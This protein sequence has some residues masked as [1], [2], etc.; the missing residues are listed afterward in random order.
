MIESTDELVSLQI[1]GYRTM[2]NDALV[3]RLA[4]SNNYTFVFLEGNSQPLLTSKPLKYF[5]LQLPHF[6]RVSKSSLV[7]PA[8]IDKVSRSTA[9]SLTLHLKDGT[10]I[11][12]SRRRSA[13]TLR[14]VR[15]YQQ[16]LKR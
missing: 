6:I 13:D 7:N 4:G 12:V 1:P 15:E 11:T 5:E 9:R 14:K 2:Q 3:I 16:K 8:Y 10:P